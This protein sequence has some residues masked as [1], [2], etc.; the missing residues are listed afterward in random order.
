MSIYFDCDYI[1]IRNFCARGESSQEKLEIR[2][3]KLNTHIEENYGQKQK[4]FAKNMF[5]S[6][7]LAPDL[8]ILQKFALSSQKRKQKGENIYI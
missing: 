8:I 3:Q 6:E 1:V 5:G 7:E 4:C 2:Q